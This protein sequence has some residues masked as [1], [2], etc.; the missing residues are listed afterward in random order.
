MFRAPGVCDNLI[1]AFKLLVN[2]HPDGDFLANVSVESFQERSRLKMMEELLKFI[3]M[4]N[5]EPVFREDTGIA[6]SGEA[7][8]H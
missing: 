2:Q 7:Q 1:N 8:V 6:S 4:D 5:R 3:T